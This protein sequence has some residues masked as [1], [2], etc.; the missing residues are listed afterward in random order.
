MIWA[1]RVKPG[2]VK[3]VLHAQV[4]GFFELF[5]TEKLDLLQ[6]EEIFPP[7]LVEKVKNSRGFVVTTQTTWDFA[8]SPV[9]LRMIT[10]WTTQV[11]LSH[12]RLMIIT[13]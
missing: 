5:Q 8:V 6:T 1:F 2:N 12:V 4:R 7:K 9:L 3:N 11:L 10:T 13:T